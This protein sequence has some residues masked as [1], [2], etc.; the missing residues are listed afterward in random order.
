MMRYLTALA[1]LIGSASC[2]SACVGY[3]NAFGIERDKFVAGM[4]S[5]GFDLK[6]A[7]KCDKSVNSCDFKFEHGSGAVT[8]KD[9]C[10]TGVIGFI[11]NRDNRKTSSLFMIAAATAIAKE[12]IGERLTKFMLT[13][14]VAD[15]DK[16]VWHEEKERFAVSYTMRAGTSTVEVNSLNILTAERLQ[17]VL[18]GM[19]DDAGHKNEVEKKRL[20]EKLKDGR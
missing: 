10:V 3:K 12:D 19:A 6:I 13:A 16:F 11:D 8:A 2:A 20:L 4:K 5:A 7:R 9:G 18:N 1:I 14:T 17:R 15:A